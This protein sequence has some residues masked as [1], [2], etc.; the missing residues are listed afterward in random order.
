MKDYTKA[1]KEKL[2]KNGW[3]FLRHG[4]KG[5]HDIWQSPDGK[6]SVAINNGM[7]SRHLANKIL[8]RANL[9]ERFR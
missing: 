1:I 7:K 5:S 3:S 8:A 4:G 6:N 2:S 9:T